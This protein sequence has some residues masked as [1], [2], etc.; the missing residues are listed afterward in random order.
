MLGLASLQPTTSR[1]S[2]PASTGF[3]IRLILPLA[4]AIAASQHLRSKLQPATD[5]A[6]PLAAAKLN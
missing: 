2:P 1:H 3:G 4:A 6:P 5:T